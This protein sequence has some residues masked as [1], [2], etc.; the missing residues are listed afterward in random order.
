MSI[1]VSLGKDSAIRLVRLLHLFALF[2]LVQT[3]ILL[4]AGLV[5]FLGLAVMAGIYLYYHLQLRAQG[6]GRF[7]FMCNTQVAIAF[8]AT[9][10][11]VLLWQ[12]LL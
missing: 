12:R 4:Q 9:S 6:P 8:L 5:Y 1:P 10:V 3:G 11:G 7:F 2:S